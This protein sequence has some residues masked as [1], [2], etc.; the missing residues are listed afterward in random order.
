MAVLFCSC[1]FDDELAEDMDNPTESEQ[2][3]ISSE[4][5]DTFGPY[6]DT[7]MGGDTGT[8]EGD[9]E[10]NADTAQLPDECPGSCL[11]IALI[12]HL[13]SAALSWRGLSGRVVFS[14]HALWFSSQL[15]SSITSSQ[16]AFISIRTILK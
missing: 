1:F 5:R 4:T 12:H 15:V 11:P 9:T 10:T 16:V 13:Q 6:S 8:G 2:D 14:A 3:D 7:G